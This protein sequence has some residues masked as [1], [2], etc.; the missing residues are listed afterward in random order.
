MQQ[1]RPLRPTRTA[2]IGRRSR[3]RWP[4]PPT[5]LHSAGLQV[6]KKVHGY[7]ERE[8]GGGRV[9]GV[10]EKTQVKSKR[11]R[12]E[13]FINLPRF[14][15]GCHLCAALARPGRFDQRQSGQKG[16]HT[17][18]RLAPRHVPRVLLS[19]RWPLIFFLLLSVSSEM[20]A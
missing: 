4:A 14:F 15:C 1:L 18:H 7:C 3:D 8:R 9:G 2:L 17:H 20:S 16:A 13:I 10:E 11:P 19:V 6:G 12:R 5:S